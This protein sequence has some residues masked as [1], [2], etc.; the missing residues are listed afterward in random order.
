MPLRVDL[1]RLIQL[2]RQ[3]S[4]EGANFTLDHARPRFEPI[5]LELERG[6]EI[7]IGDLDSHMSVLSYRGRQ[8]LL[9]IRDHSSQF[10]RAV[11]DPARNGNRFHIA[12]C[13]QLEKMK[14]ANRYERYVA[15]TRLDGFFTIEDAGDWS[16]S[17]RTADVRLRVCQFCVGRLNYKNAGFSRAS[18]ARIAETFSISHFFSHYSTC[19]QHAPVALAKAASI[20]YTMDWG[21]V[22]RRAREAAQYCCSQC[23]VDLQSTRRLCDVHH[24]NGVKSDNSDSNL[25]VLC[26]D[27]HRKQPKHGGIFLSMADMKTLQKLRIEQGKLAGADWEEV[28]ALSDTSIHGDLAVL[29]NDGFEAPQVGFDLTGQNGEVIATVEAAWPRRRTAV[30]LIKIDVPGWKI[31]QVGEVCGGLG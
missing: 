31:Y 22:S 12:H 5:D 14:R 24:R 16:D 2:G 18:R 9:Y 25:Q 30:S 23:G 3:M 13:G 19:F 29:R 17:P 26:R 1:S 27:C 4:P 20:G 8:V 15:T 7:E 28:Y 11:V 21:E 10:D 6:K